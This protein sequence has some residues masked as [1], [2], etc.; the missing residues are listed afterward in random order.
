MKY[1]LFVV[2]VLPLLLGSNVSA[3]EIL[4]D[5]ASLEAS[6]GSNAT[7]IDFENINLGPLG[8]A[9][10]ALDIGQPLDPSTIITSPFLTQGP[11]LVP[12]GIAF[13]PKT[14]P[15][16]AP[17]WLV[18]NP[19]N[20]PV[21]L[22]ITVSLGTAG[23][24]GGA[25]PTALLIDFSVPVNAFGLDLLS[26]GQPFLNGAN[27]FSIT[28]LGSDDTTVLQTLAL[29]VSSPIFTGGREFFGFSG[30]EEVGGVMFQAQTVFG[31]DDLT[32]GTVSPV[33][34]PSTL[35]LLGFGVTGVMAWRKLR[36]R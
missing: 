12:S 18:L 19:P 21:P 26:P 7:T 10:I 16:A 32:Y 6:V 29:N 2:A 13:L 3:D 22:D 24:G 27:T 28:I 30:S 8:L 14:E 20:V 1:R 17:G 5:R 25:P 9:Q 31:V 34:E 33:P 36:G 35:L 23:G 15:L 4:S 11:G